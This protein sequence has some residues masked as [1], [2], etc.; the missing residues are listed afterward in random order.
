MGFARVFNEVVTIGG[1]AERALV[2]PLGEPADE[3]RVAPQAVETMPSSSTQVTLASRRRMDGRCTRDREAFVRLDAM[4]TEPR[5]PRIQQLC[6]QIIGRSA[7]S[8]SPGPVSGHV[9]NRVRGVDELAVSDDQLSDNALRCSWQVVAKPIEASR[10][11]RCLGPASPP[12][13]AC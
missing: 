2:A 13:V 5:K 9:V 11:C 8:L 4:L 12:V 10:A 6:T 1:F 3:D 7:E